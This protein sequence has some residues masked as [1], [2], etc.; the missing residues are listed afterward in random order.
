MISRKMKS[1]RLSKDEVAFDIVNMTL[2]ILFS[3]CCLLPLLN[4]F[5]K[6]VSSESAVI[7]GKVVFFPVDFQF[8]SILFMLRQYGFQKS[9]LN[10]VKVT[11]LGTA[12]NAVVTV[13]AAYPLSR[14]RL[15]GRRVLH[16]IIVFTMLFNGG[17][18]PTFILIQRLGLLET[19]GSI[20]L[21][22]ACNAYWVIIVRNYFE[23]IPDALEDSARID[24]ASNFRTFISV[25]LP[26][27]LPCIATLVVF[28]AVALWN[29]Y[30]TSLLY[31]HKRENFTLQLY[32]RQLL[33]SAS[34]TSGSMLVDSSQMRALKNRSPL[35]IQAAAVF[36]S[37]IPILIV[38]PFVQRYFVKGMTL[39]AVKG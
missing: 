8:E 17:L 5:A 29:E 11:L 37:T 3:A 4:L 35:I 21:P 12:L 22:W 23:G 36:L 18:I 39:G 20:I 16:F 33:D 31:L 27:A 6:A 34:G 38:Y 14:K 1:L 25:M 15:R 9:F 28:S 32:L 26:L 30:F 2:L 10:S 13:M 7:R 24:G 19:H